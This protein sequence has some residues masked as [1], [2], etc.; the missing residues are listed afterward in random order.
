MKNFKHFSAIFRMPKTLNL[1]D[2]SHLTFWL[3]DPLI[4]VV[5]FFCIFKVLFSKELIGR[6]E[7]NQIPN[8][9]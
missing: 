7:R 3:L 1:F 9:D 8:L 4:Q 6:I 5:K 2:R